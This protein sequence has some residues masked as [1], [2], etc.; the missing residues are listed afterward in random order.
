MTRFIYLADSHIGANPMGYHQ[1]NAYPEHMTEIA[2]A[3]TKMAGGLAPLDF[4]L[5]GGDMIDFTSKD[6]IVAASRIFDVGLPV[7]LCLGNH[8]LTSDDALEQWLTHAPEFFPGASPDFSLITA[9]CVIHVLPNQ[10]GE[11]P[12]FWKDTQA[13]AFTKGQHAW[14]NERLASDSHKP[15]LLLTHSPVLGVPPQQTGFDHPFHAPPATFR[16]EVLGICGKC[17]TI[18]CVLGA[19]SHINTRERRDNVE[20]ITVSA[21]AEMPFEIKLFEVS[22]EAM[23]MTTMSLPLSLQ[24]GFLYDSSRSYIQGTGEHRT[25]TMP[26]QAA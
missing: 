1:Q 4:V 20:F 5:H 10:W 3:L 16:D 7:Y 18:R 15:Q 12:F 14:L 21:L 8:D 25:F 23:S 24:R 11:K 9:D 22:A 19:H 6:N 26:L 17:S 2:A 13:P